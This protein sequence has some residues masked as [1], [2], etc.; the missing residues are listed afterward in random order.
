MNDRFDTWT[1]HLG[2]QQDRRGLLKTAAVGA[3]GLLGV[4]ALS[5]DALAKKCNNNNDCNGKD[6]CK[7]GKCVECK[8]NGNCKKNEKCKQGKCRH[9]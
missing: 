8:N 3:M 6:K 5:D 7:G 1:K 2:A 4:A 9:K